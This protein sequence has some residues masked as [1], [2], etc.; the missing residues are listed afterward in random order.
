MQEMQGRRRRRR[1]RRCGCENR[2]AAQTALLPRTPIFS[3]PLRGA[4]AY[5]A[6]AWEVWGF[7]AAKKRAKPRATPSRP[8]T[9][10]ESAPPPQK[11]T[12]IIH[13]RC[14]RRRGW[15][16]ACRG[17]SH[18]CRTRISLHLRRAS[19]A[20]NRSSARRPDLRFAAA[21]ARSSATPL[22]VWPST[23]S[24]SSAPR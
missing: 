10:L 22:P 19:A 20:N 23:P 9:G 7:A 2:V 18:L 16:C 24:R 1:Q 12:Q 11:L 3:E 5:G 8:Q 15:R 17:S 4:K 14:V 21:A 13:L 6:A